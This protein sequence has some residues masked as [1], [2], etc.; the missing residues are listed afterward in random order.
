MY[1]KYI[2]LFN[3]ILLFNLS[4]G[5]LSFNK[6]I[7][8][9]FTILDSLNDVNKTD[10]SILFLPEGVGNNQLSYKSYSNFL[11]ELTEKK[12]KTYIPESSDNL[13]DNCDKL[14]KEL[15]EKFVIV[16]HSSSAVKSIDIC[17]K[18]NN[19]SKVVL[20]NPISIDY[21]T[22]QVKSK[23]PKVNIS[24]PNIY[25]LYENIPFYNI[26]LESLSEF[27]YS[28]TIEDKRNTTE[29]VDFIS[30]N[31]SK[32][33]YKINIINKNKIIKNEN[34]NN[35]TDLMIISS[36]M[37]KKWKIFPFIPPIGLL[38]I[39]KDDF[40]LNNNTEIVEHSFDF[41]HYDI[42]DLT[43]SDL[44][45]NSASK[46]TDNREPKNLNQYHKDLSDKILDFL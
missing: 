45:H 41:G 15:D 19:I 2:F 38:N 42:L 43:W 24:F 9:K 12:I 37:S 34:K 1:F 13:I 6:S 40:N 17:S 16:S 5:F 14:M 33:P 39:N 7:K 31:L 18:N 26:V 21:S 32:F 30:E 35:I 8:N 20:I 10:F 3:I 36:E 44:I 46:G 27:P 28:V 22:Q 23:L 29:K 25:D 4:N 11:R